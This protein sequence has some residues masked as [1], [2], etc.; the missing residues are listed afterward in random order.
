M[1]EGNHI[2]SPLLRSGLL[3][4]YFFDADFFLLV[5]LRVVDFRV[6]DLRL[7][8][9]RAVDLRLEDLR[10]VDLRLEDLRLADLRDADLPPVDF[11]RDDLRGTFAPDSRASDSA[12]AIACFLLLTVLPDRPLFSVPALRLCIARLTFLPAAFPYFAM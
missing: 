5:D 11:F 4:G 12:I 8:D 7:L 6:V 3:R 1:K 2:G 9:L 10:A